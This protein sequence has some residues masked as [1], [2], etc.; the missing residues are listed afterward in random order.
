MRAVR[1]TR[2]FSSTAWRER[3][4]LSRV[5]PDWNSPTMALAGT[6]F[7]RSTSMKNAQSVW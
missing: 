2:P 1:K 4:A 3:K 5:W 7:L 6:P